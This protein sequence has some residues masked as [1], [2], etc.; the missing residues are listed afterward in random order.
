MR[1][2]TVTGYISAP[3][4]RIYDFL[5]DLANRPSHCDH[6]ELEYHLARAN[7]VGLGAAARFK[8]DPPL[9]PK[10]WVELAIVEADEPRRIVEEGRYMRWGRSRLLVI[11]ELVPDVRGVTRVELRIESEPATR[12]DRFKESFGARGWLKRKA[13]KAVARMRVIF[14]EGQAG[15]LPRATVAGYEPL[16]APRFGAHLPPRRA[17]EGSG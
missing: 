1:P 5:E 15:E 12:I 14:E 16:K 17:R 4:E 6:F 8:L 10:T 7:S 2:F 3:R 13:K 9:V 11:W